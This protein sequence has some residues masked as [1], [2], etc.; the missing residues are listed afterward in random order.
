MVASAFPVLQLDKALDRYRDEV[1]HVVVKNHAR[2]K[3][4]S[5]LQAS[6]AMGKLEALSGTVIDL[7]EL[8]A[9][10]MYKID[11]GGLSYWAGAHLAEGGEAAFET[12]RARTKRQAVAQSR[13]PRR[14]TSSA[15]RSE[16]R[17]GSRVPRQPDPQPAA[18]KV[19]RT[20][21]AAVGV[22]L[23]RQRETGP[24]QHIATP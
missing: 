17:R 24:R 20:A 12:A 14:S 6:P 9:S 4:F 22:V 16:R 23:V 2:S 15:L 3:D 19:D 1:A 8:D 11:S 13:L 5:Q 21:T 7:P 10:A 18:K